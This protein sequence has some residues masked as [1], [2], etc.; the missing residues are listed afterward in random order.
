MRLRFVAKLDTIVQ[1]MVMDI[2]F[3]DVITPG[4]ENLEY[5][6]LLQ[7]LPAANVLAYSLETVEAE[8]FEAMIALDVQNSRYKDFFDLYRILQDGKLDITI[9]EEA[10]TNT[11]DNRQTILN[12]TPAVLTSVFYEDKQRQAFWN[13]FLRKIK[14]GTHIDFIEVGNTIISALSP[15]YKKI[16]QEG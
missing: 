3:G 5:P 8:K 1:P 7:S 15:L 10:I 4:P 12:E 11:F 16:T 14:W 9:L 13:G 6:A 2:V